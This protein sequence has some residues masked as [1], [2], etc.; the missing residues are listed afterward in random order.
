LNLKTAIFI[1]R[2]GVENIAT[3]IGTPNATPLKSKVKK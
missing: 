1:A 3:P 2:Q